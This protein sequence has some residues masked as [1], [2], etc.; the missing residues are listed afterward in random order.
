M[1]PLRCCGAPSWFNVCVMTA[2]ASSP[3]AFDPTARSA[4][5]WGSRLA[6]LRSH[7]VGDDDPRIAESEAG[8]QYWRLVRE[9]DT[10]EAAGVLTQA[11]ASQV[12]GLYRQQAIDA[13]AGKLA[14]SGQSVAGG[15]APLDARGAV[16]GG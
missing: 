15:A 4:S 10:A 13:V 3:D 6:G 12:R 11:F 9:I 16:I 5:S 14:E 1:L 7:N 8:L 2:A